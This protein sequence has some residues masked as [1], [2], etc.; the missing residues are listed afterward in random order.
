MR[1][2]RGEDSQ[3]T[4]SERVGISQKYL[5]ELERGCKTPSWPMLLDIAHRGFNV[6]VATLLCGV[7]ESTP[8]SIGLANCPFHAASVRPATARGPASALIDEP[9]QPE[10]AASSS[11]K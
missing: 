5:S 4:V 2:L 7:D 8:L 3:Q 6:T 11:K 9:I 1:L 10:G